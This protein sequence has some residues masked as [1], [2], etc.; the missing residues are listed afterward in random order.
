MA[1]LKTSLPAKKCPRKECSK[2]FHPEI[3]NQKYCSIKC[4]DIAN[5]EAY[6]KRLREKIREEL[7]A[8][9]NS[10]P[11]TTYVL[12]GELLN[13]TQVRCKYRHKGSYIKKENRKE[14]QD[15]ELR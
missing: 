11:P 3:V 12:P 8:E 15:Y 10:N 14:K 1:K 2:F 5:N 4:R 9:M 6:Q 13:V 7:L